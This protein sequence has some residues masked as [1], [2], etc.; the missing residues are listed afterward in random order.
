MI[1]CALALH[2]SF[3]SGKSTDVMVSQPGLG[4][5]LLARV[6]SV[7]LVVTVMLVVLATIST[8][9]ITQATVLDA[10]RPSALARAWWWR[11]TRSKTRDP[12][13]GQARRGIGPRPP[14]GPGSWA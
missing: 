2:S 10:R 12:H 6:D 4:N 11:S 7:V 1:V 9:F 3:A 14:R 13:P 8:I 5:P